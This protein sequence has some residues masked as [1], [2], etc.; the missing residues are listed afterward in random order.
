MTLP[1]LR[2]DRSL[3]GSMIGSVGDTQEV[4]RFC[5][6]HEIMP[7]SKV[8]KLEEINEAIER[9]KNANVQFRFVIDLKTWD[10]E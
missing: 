8:I 6:K 7:I 10:G 1:W 2:R 9:L 4:L 3:T 5:A